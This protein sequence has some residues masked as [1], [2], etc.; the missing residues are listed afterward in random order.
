[1]FERALDLVGAH[2]DL[3]QRLR[4]IPPSARARGI[5][6]RPF[7]G[8]LARRGLMDRYLA[9]FDAPV[10]ALAWH[11]CGEVAARLAVAG[12]LYASPGE[13]HAGMRELGRAQAVHFSESLLGRTLLRILSPDPVRVLQQ[14]AAA[15]RQGC[16]YGHWEHDFSIPGKAIVTHTDEYLW[17][18]SQV[19]G[20]AEGTF[21]AIKVPARFE[22]RMTNAYNGVTEITWNNG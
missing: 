19:L 1:M 5:W 4:D 11:S 21:E 9:I 18:D 3:E 14:G 15:R 7:E 10:S 17:L 6:V 8:A 16:D 2:C 22:L 13:V 20:S 12:A